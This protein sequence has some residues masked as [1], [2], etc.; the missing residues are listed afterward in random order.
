VAAKLWAQN[1][2]ITIEDMIW[3]YEIN[4]VGGESKNYAEKTLRNWI[5]DLCLNR[6][7]GAHI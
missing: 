2:E 6:S 5:K 3:K 7:L 4:L 1:P